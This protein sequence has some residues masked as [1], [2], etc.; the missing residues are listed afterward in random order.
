[1]ELRY[2]VLDGKQPVEK[3]S[4]GGHPWE[5]VKDFANL[6][7]LVPEPYIVLDFDSPSDDAIMRRIVDELDIKCRVMKTTR[8]HHYWFKS[9]EPWKNFKATRLAIGVNSDC[10]S[11][12]KLSYVKVKQDGALREWEK[13]IPEEEIATVPVWLKPLNFTKYVFKGMGE[14]DGRNQDLFNYILVMQG[15]GYTPEQIKKTISIINRFVFADPLPESE[16]DTICRS[17]AF[18]EPGDIDPAGDFFDEDGKFQHNVFATALASSMQIATVNNQLYLYKDGYYQAARR[19]IE[20]RMIDIY[21]KIKQRQRGEVLD[22]IKIITEKHPEDMSVDEYTINLKNTRL[23]LRDETCLPFD[24]EALD[25]CRIPVVYNPSAHCAALDKTLN[26]VFC[27]DREVIDLFEEMVGYGLIKNC[28]FRKGFLFY[29]GGSNGKST[30]LNLLKRFFGAENCATVELEKLE[31]R[32][33]TAELENKLVNIGDDID[34]RDIISTGTIKKLFTGESVTVERK[35]QDP[36]T[37]KSY[38]KMIFSCNEIPRIADKSHGMYSRL[39]LIPFKATFS[40]TD[41]DFDPFIED[42]LNT[43]EAMSYLLNIA[44]RGLR[45]LLAN[46]RF[47]QPSVVK[48]AMSKYSVDNST[49]LTW[50]ADEGLTLSELVDTRTETLFSQFQGWCSRSNIKNNV[51]L[52]TFHKDIED[53]Y[54]LTRRRVR[55]A[56]KGKYTWQFVV[57]LD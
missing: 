17:D 25:F 24:A 33:K 6:G 34:R 51:S 40:P 16:I 23:N 52:R 29:G 1:M 45:R 56:D 41:A 30:I 12:G 39:M 7:L 3:L 46:N 38:A 53:R 2:I 27:A 26:K 36:F 43:D 8:G 21:P 31:D 14:G 54:G 20:Q 42:K 44:L 55:S 5:E 32:F 11:W 10:R 13:L 15:K 49:V 19:T 57:K 47:T 28:R 18:R 35:G 4:D 37:L 22:Y 9:D 50:I 48:E